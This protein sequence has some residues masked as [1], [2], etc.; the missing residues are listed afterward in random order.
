MQTAAVTAAPLFAK[1]DSVV[2]TPSGGCHEFQARVLTA[3]TD[4]SCTVEVQWVVRDE[5]LAMGYYGD[6]YRVG[7]Q[8]LSVRTKAGTPVGRLSHPAAK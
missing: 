4:G 5:A 7:N 2:Y 8:H 6:K 3:H 1:G